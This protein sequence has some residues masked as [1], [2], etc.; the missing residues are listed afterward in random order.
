MRSP[1]YKVEYAEMTSWTDEVN[2]HEMAGCDTAIFGPVSYM[3]VILNGRRRRE[4]R[5]AEL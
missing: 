1:G 5:D 2:L 4:I 3:L